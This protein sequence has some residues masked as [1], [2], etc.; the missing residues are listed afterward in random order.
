M[1]CFSERQWLKKYPNPELT[2]QK[3]SLNSF[4]SNVSAGKE[5]GGNTGISH[6]LTP[7]SLC[8][9]AW[10]APNA[11]PSEDTPSKRSCWCF[12]GRSHEGA[13]RSQVL[14][15]ATLK[16][17]TLC[18]N[19][20][21]ST[22]SHSPIPVL[23]ADLGMERVINREGERV[24]A[25]AW[26]GPGSGYP[27]PRCVFADVWLMMWEGAWC[28]WELLSSGRRCEERCRGLQPQDV[29]STALWP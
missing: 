13:Q 24:P 8:H 11:C 28:P 26:V 6:I 15:S 5:H 20:T 23:W 27:R 9:S 4:E 29:T 19:L 2:A 7:L 1:L 14:T 22:T 12:P 16:K 17:E 10:E 3:T 21:K 25:G 18:M